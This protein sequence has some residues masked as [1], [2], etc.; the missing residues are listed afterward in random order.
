MLSRVADT[1][2][3]MSRYLER[4]EHTARVVDVNL[5]LMLDQSPEAAGSR[6][7]RVVAALRIASTSEGSAVVFEENDPYAVARRLA[8]NP[9]DRSSIVTSISFARENA[10]QTRELLS[11]EMW[12]QLNRLYLYVRSH[13]HEGA[14]PAQLGEFLQTIKEGAYLFHGITDDTLGRSEC[15]RFLE[16]GR[17]L[18][19]AGAIAGMIDLH[20]GDPLDP[21]SATDHHLEWVGLLKSCAAFEAYCKVYTADLHPGR[22]ADFLL[23]NAEFPHSLRFAVDRVQSSLAAIASTTGGHKADRLGR[24]AGRV[25]ATLGFGLIDEILE[26][27]LRPY[28][29]D[30]QKQLSQIHAG[31]YQYYI[32]Y[33]I[34]SALEA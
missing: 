1:L 14:L 11:S 17:Y 13:T 8:F 12:E 27:G 9:E 29:A 2:Y 19:R 10:R 31:I 15:W 6:W 22:I 23:L 5:N 21:T 4:A 25:Q 16:L 30:I 32:A 34:E 24:M 26:T 3:W 28:V 33:P 7:G 20:L 18:E